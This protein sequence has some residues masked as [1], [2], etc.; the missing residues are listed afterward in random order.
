M[1]AHSRAEGT[2]Q[3]ADS[4][5]VE[6]DLTGL[7]PYGRYALTERLTLWGVTGYG[8]GTLWLTP[9]GQDTIETR[10]NLMMGGLGLRGVVMKAKDGKGPEVAL[11]TDALGVRTTSDKTRGLASAEADV[12]R[13]RMG[14]EGTWHGIELRSN[15]LKPRLELGVR[16]DGGDAET[17][18]GVDVGGGLEWSNEAMGL[19]ASVSGRGLLTH[20]ADGFG[21]RGFAG[22]LSFDPRPKSDRGIAFTM[23]Q[24]VGSSATGGM[25]T[26]LGRRTLDS[27]GDGDELE[28]RRLELRLG[29]GMPAFGGGF[30]ATPELGLG[31]SGSA[32]D[33]RAGWRLGLARS[34]PASAELRLEATR[35]E[36]TS[37][38]APE[39][40]V[41]L[42]LIA[43]W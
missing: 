28:N 25:E 22:T 2:Y 24:T 38:E 40:A 12:T 19:R 11:T 33:Y 18:F 26:L 36:A 21:N 43:R 10:M 30:T 6:N 8:A 37:A 1:L 32:R 35:H 23:S 3:G 20:E 16:H 14:A 15:A 39:H 31:L 41:G 7:Y 17:G 5:T 29:Y 34:G 4:G 9:E 27:L 42:S 13:L